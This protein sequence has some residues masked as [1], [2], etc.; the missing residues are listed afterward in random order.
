MKSA[1]FGSL[2]PY[3]RARVVPNPKWLL[4]QEMVAWPTAENHHRG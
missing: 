1:S 4:T 3:C 2:M